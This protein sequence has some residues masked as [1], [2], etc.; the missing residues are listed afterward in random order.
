MADHIVPTEGFPWWPGVIYEPDD[1]RIP[2]DA[3]EVYK[4]RSGAIDE[5][6]KATKMVYIVNFY[7]A[8]KTW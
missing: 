8:R 7:D 4:V 2:E 6:T 1:P 3:K 5:K